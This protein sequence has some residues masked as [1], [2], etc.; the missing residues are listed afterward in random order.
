[1]DIKNFCDNGITEIKYYGHTVIISTIKS[2]TILDLKHLKILIDDLIKDQSD[3]DT[4]KT[5]IFELNLVLNELKN[6]AK[7]RR[8]LHKLE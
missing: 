8:E 5:N 4:K 7:L 3:S 2:I 6:K 1:M